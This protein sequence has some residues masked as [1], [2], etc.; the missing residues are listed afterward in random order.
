MQGVESSPDLWIDLLEALKAKNQQVLIQLL[1]FEY[2]DMGTF[3][4]IPSLT[5]LDSGSQK[6]V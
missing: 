4:W 5:A 2:S 6:N 3:K 1:P